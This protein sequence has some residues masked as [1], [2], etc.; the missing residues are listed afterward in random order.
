MTIAFTWQTEDAE[1]LLATCERDGVFPLVVKYFPPGCRVL[2]SGCGL[3]RYVKYLH[4]RGWDVVGLEFL[5]STVDQV[6]S[7]WPEIKIELGDVA[8]SS[9][10]DRSFDGIMSLG[11]VEHW[12]EGPGRPL[13]EIF[14]LL[15]PGGHAIIT[16]PVH[17][18]VR[19]WKRRLWFPEITR[20]PLA[21]FSRLTT[22]AKKPMNR[23]NRVYRYAVMPPYGDFFEYH[24]TVHEY[25]E[26]LV[27]AG[28]TIVEHVPLGIIDGL[29]HDVNPLGMLVRFQDWKFRP[30]RL[31]AWLNARLA[32]TPF[33]HCHMQ[34]AVVRRPDDTSP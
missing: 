24:M 25:R 22:G 7:I 27:Q 23:L 6:R 33:L 2:E 34:A 3:G 11:V 13:R 12:P 31:G 20:F 16:V 26:E 17:N 9:F 21:L 30:S 4:D 8:N 1:S 5:R 29:Y 28:F 32:R 14:R 19:Q 18:T 10:P 15:K